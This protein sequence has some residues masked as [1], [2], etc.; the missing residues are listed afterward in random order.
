M[1]KTIFSGI[2]TVLAA[3]LFTA[4]E[5]DNYDEPSI[6]FTG[7]IVYNGQNVL[8]D[9]DPAKPLFRVIQTGYGKTDN[10]TA[11][12]TSADGSFAHLL[13][14]GRYYFT[15]Q[16]NVYPF[17]FP[18]YP[19]LGESEGY[20]QTRLDLYE[21]FSMNVEAIPYYLISDFTAYFDAETQ[22][23]HMQCSVTPNTDERLNGVCPA[24]T[25]VRGFV[26]TST[27]VNSVT[28]CVK[29]SSGRWPAFS[30]TST[31]DIP[32]EDY[33][34]AYINNFRDYGYCRMAFELEGIPDYYLY[35]PVIKVEGLPVK[36]WGKL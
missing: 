21:D 20:P 18:E 11:I 15:P 19:Y 2:L 3:C 33:H 12:Q 31:Q 9:G 25:S 34:D 35:T 4:C 10:G 1:K 30:G 29:N 17:V 16:N 27:I 26:S 6:V 13:F 5:Y 36:E 8:Y 24:I 7:N 23:I 28:T 22:Q 14:P 32:I